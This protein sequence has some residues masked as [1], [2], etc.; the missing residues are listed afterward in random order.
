MNA[1]ETRAKALEQEGRD[2]LRVRDLVCTFE[3]D[4][5]HP[6]AQRSRLYAVNGISFT[7]AQGEVFGLVGESGCGK[8]T[9]A[10]AVLNAHRADAGEIRFDDID[11][12]RANASQWKQ[13]RRRIQYV[14]QDPLGALDPRMT[15]LD[16]IV[17]PLVI[18]GIGNKSE[19]QQRARELMLSVRLGKD[20]EAKFPHELS[21][22]QRQRV[23]IAR[24]LILEPELLICDEPVSAL[25]VS[26]QAQVINL[27]RQ[28]RLEL[29]LTLLF[30]S[31]DLSLV[32]YLCSR[33]AIMYL[34]RIVEM[35]RTKDI[36]ENPQ[37]PYTQALISAIPVADP[38]RPLK[39]VP[40]NDE[41]PNPLSLPDGCHFHPRCPYAL[42]ECRHQAPD[43]QSR[44]N[45]QDVA[46]HLQQVEA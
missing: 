11:L 18:H 5:S 38:G 10:K 15:A 24:A 43:L 34:G 6:F 39:P 32:R 33:V 7:L 42:E 41:L 30:I 25:D 21:G 40:L 23:V 17:E 36:F 1:P 8:S 45:R 20:V 13:I 9:T 37:H 27:L 16:Q 22:G 31:H 3:S 19:R 28:L 12:H 4:R 29:D 44:Q 35:G 46:C 26:V 2:L 14:F